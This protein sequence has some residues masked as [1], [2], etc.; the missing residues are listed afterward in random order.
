MG[1]HGEPAGRVVLGFDFPI[2]LPFAYA[3]RAGLTDFPS[4]LTVF[5]TGEWSDFFKV[6]TDKSEITL[7]RPFYPAKCSEKDIVKVAHLEEQLGLGYSQLFRTC[8]LA[9]G[10]GPTAGMMFWTLGSKQVG[11]GALKGWREVL[12]PAV[13]D[14][15]LDVALWPFDGAFDD[16]VRSRAVTV[17]ETYPAEM[18]SHLRVRFLP[19]ESKR[20]QRDRQ[21]KGP[22]L[23]QWA[24]QAGVDLTSGLRGEIESGFGPRKDGEDPFDAVVGLFGILNVLLGHRTAGDPEPGSDE[25]Q[26]EGWILGRERRA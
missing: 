21:G 20:R 5:G 3:R 7:H 19:R 17:V 26:I 16:L 18:Y 2:G 13:T 9:A 4:P 15:N 22:A 6:A 12:Q 23:L 24:E 10:G 1:L 25:Q 14:P 8:E 11:K